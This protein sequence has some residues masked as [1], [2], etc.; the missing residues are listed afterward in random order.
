MIGKKL[1]KP[2]SGFF[3]K[4]AK[5]IM[6]MDIHPNYI[7]VLALVPAFFAAYFVIIK[8][9]YVAAAFVALTGIVDLLDGAVARA[10]KKITKFGSYLDAMIDRY[11]EVVIYFGFLIAGFYLGAFLALSGGILLSYAKARVA[12]VKK[13]SNDD[14]PSLG[15]RFEKF[16]ILFLGLLLANYFDSIVVI[17]C[18]L[19]LLALINHIGALQRIFYARKII[20]S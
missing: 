8:S 4:I 9:Y 16:F 11:V 6:K 19:Y 18:M 13:I 3:E 12:L 17:A 15:D 2:S 20:K 5:L 1:R 7:S 10:A 14:W